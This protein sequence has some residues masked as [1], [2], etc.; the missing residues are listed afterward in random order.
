MKYDFDTVID[1]KNTKSLKHDFY[2]EHK[3]PVDA[4][5]MWVADMDF[6]TAPCVTEAMKKDLEL[7]IF[8]YSEP[9]EPYYQAVSNWFASRF[10]WN[11]QKEWLVKTPGVVFALTTAICSLT[12]KGDAVLIQQ[13]VYY[14]FRKVI[15][16]NGRVCVNSSLVYSNS[17]Y[18][19][20][21]HDFEEKIVQNHVKMF[22]LCSPHNPVGRVWTKEELL[23]VIAICR[24]HNVFIVS[25]E[26]HADFVYPG[27][28]HIVLAKLADDYLDHMII[29]TSP[30]KTFN[31]AGLQLSNIF[32]PDEEV[33]T[34]FVKRL[35]EVSYLEAGMLALTACE[36][37]YTDGGEWLDELLIYL[38]ENIGYVRNFLRE[39]LGKLH[40]VEPEGTYLLWLDFSE[41][42]YTPQE[43]DT[44]MLQEVKLWLDAGAIF[45]AE[46]NCFER[47]N[48]ACPRSILIQAMERLKRTFGE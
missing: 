35:H 43:L 15:E 40:M 7:G 38:Q 20:D 41:Y 45:G 14:P 4:I 33:R 6:R 21:F 23:T 24:K 16:D 1:R 9:L 39:N 17:H 44:K 11:L 27:H 18:E 25:D 19:M 2:E 48:I 30:S 26:I 12:E 46:G 8:G 22:I 5:S 42:G 37:A 31:L 28:H 3:I 10:G 36:A 29:C 32:I 13:P 47:I 34:K